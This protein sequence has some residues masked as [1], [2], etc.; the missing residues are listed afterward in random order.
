MHNFQFLYLLSIAYVFIAFNA[1][2]EKKVTEKLSRFSI[3]QRRKK[4]NEK[5]I[6]QCTRRDSKHF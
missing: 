4:A 6:E 5:E 3:T 1:D 2:D